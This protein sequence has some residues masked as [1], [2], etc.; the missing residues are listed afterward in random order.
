MWLILLSTGFTLALGTV[1][2]IA[3]EDYF[4]HDTWTRIFAREPVV[5]YPI[6][7]VHGIAGKTEEWDRTMKT[8]VGDEHFH[9]RYYDEES[10]YHNY[11]GDKPKRWVW[12]ISYY[13]VNVLGESFRGDL[14]L[15]AQRLQKMIQLIQKMSGKDKVVIITHSMGGL[16]ARKYMTLD[17]TCWNSVHR[18][19][20]VGSPN[21]GVATSVGVVG[22]LADLRRGS[23]FICQLNTEWALMT[24]GERKWGV[25]GALDRR[26]YSHTA[27]NPNATDSGGPG[28]IAISSSIPLEWD[29]ALGNQFGKAATNT[30]HYGFRLAV[31]ARHLDLLYH[32][33]TF[34][35]IH[36]ALKK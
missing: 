28:F 13:T 22:Q 29:D 11:Y 6:I 14:T 36:W 8:L 15:Y 26:I 10:I 16:V 4:A 35:G 20:T 34:R 33:G 17:R 27:F 3:A 12:S 1:S 18:I 32:E 9:M 21:E 24:K 30:L 19:L 25:I 2:A 23:A 7:F 5:D 31:D